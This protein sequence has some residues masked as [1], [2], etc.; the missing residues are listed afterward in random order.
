MRLASHMSPV[1]NMKLF[2][3]KNG[4]KLV[5]DPAYVNLSITTIFDTANFELL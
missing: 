2:L 3:S 1:T 5:K 4:V